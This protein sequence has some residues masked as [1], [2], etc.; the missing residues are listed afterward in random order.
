VKE[1]EGYDS[2]TEVTS[3]HSSR[4]SG[5]TAGGGRT[6]SIYGSKRSHKTEVFN[7]SHK[8][9]MQHSINDL[10]TKNL[11]KVNK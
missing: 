4:V 9:V 8:N 11:G 6:R 7:V 2:A 10:L 1:E 3:Y 5:H